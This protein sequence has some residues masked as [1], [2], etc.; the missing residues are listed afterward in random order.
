MFSSPVIGQIDFVFSPAMLRHESGRT[1][2]KRI[3]PEIAF[4]TPKKLDDAI[5]DS[6]AA[7]SCNSNTNNNSNAVA[8]NPVCE[9]DQQCSIGAKGQPVVEKTS[10]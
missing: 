6:N 5:S 4:A 9:S 2:L 7:Q 10:E 1:F 3:A 8:G